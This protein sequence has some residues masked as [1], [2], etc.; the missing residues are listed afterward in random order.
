M[1]VKKSGLTPF[2]LERFGLI[3]S[4]SF[5][6]VFWRRCSCNT[7]VFIQKIYDHVWLSIVL[8]VIVSCRFWSW[9]L[10]VLLSIKFSWSFQGRRRTFRLLHQS[11]WKLWIYGYEI[12]SNEIDFLQFNNW[13]LHNVNSLLLSPGKPFKMRMG[14]VGEEKFR[15]IS[16]INNIHHTRRCN[17]ELTSSCQHFYKSTIRLI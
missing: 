3:M 16:V 13:N 1:P 9:N 15:H 14:S 5:V 8:S 7:V 2:F 10:L 12:F 17:P 4:I 11:C 6:L